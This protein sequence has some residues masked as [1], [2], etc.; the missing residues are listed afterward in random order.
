VSG[1]Y[2][3]PAS[4]FQRT[5]DRLTWRPLSRVAGVLIIGFLLAGAAST[6]TNAENSAVTG[7]RMFLGESSLQGM[8]AG[9]A[10]LLPPRVVSCG[11]CH[12]GD[13]GVGSA[14]SFAPALDRPRLMEFIARRGGP[15]TMFTP[16]SFCQTLRTGVDPA[17]IL[18]TRRMPRYIL[19]DDQCLDL[20]R[21][22]TEASNDPPKE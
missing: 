18:I 8:I 1:Q 5:Y 4:H 17:F 10:E 16:N 9:H 2:A 21:Y 14:N 19:S 12:L 7:R 22:L 20:W 3:P 6:S 15:P 13:A 11:N